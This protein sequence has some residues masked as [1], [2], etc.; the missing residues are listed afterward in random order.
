MQKF[1]ESNPGLQS[2][3]TK[4][5]TFEDY[6]PDELIIITKVILREKKL[7]LEKE[8]EDDSSLLLELFLEE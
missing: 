8:A 7:K 2:R 6:A 5:F 3:F 1:L 4:K